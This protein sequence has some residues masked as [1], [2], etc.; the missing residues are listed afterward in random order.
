MGAGRVLIDAPSPW[1]QSDE[2]VSGE[3][4]ADMFA[5]ASCVF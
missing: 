5:G 3:I 4:Q 2:N 1:Y